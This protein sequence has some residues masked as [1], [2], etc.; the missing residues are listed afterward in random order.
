M[1]GQQNIEYNLCFL[2]SSDILSY[3]DSLTFK[4]RVSYI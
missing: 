2:S 4:N 1:H 3:E